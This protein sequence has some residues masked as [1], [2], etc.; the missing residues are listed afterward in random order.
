MPIPHGPG[1]GD[2]RFELAKENLGDRVEKD[3][4]DKDELKP[5]GCS[6]K[7]RCGTGP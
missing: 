3:Q 1:L 4:K 2:E 7:G 5:R 6:G